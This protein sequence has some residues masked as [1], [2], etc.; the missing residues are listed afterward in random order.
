M[1]SYCFLSYFV[2]TVGMFKGQHRRC[3]FLT[4]KDYLTSHSFFKIKALHD[5]GY[6][7]LFPASFDRHYFSNSFSRTLQLYQAFAPMVIAIFSRDVEI[8]ACVKDS[9]CILSEHNP[10]GIPLWKFY[11]FHFWSHPNHP[12]GRLWTLNPEDYQLEGKGLFP[13]NLYLGYSIEEN[14][15]KQNFTPHAE[16][17]HQV[18][19]YGKKFSYFFGSDNVWPPDFYEAA[20]EETGIKIVMGAS[21]DQPTDPDPVL[22]SWLTN[23]GNI[24]KDVFISTVGRSKILIGQGWPAT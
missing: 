23:L 21:K 24:P 20:I 5:L 4:N 8:E 7:Y 9:S 22:P 19:I 12:L 14:C 13:P 6:T 2:L 17:D 16:R 18:Y 3:L 15:H 11:T 1:V 10:D